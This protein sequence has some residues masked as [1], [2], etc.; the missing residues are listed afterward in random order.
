MRKKW[1]IAIAAILVV[2]ICHAAKNRPVKEKP[3]VAITDAMREDW[4]DSLKV[5]AA[6]AAADL[7]KGDSASA[8]YHYEKVYSL[9]VKA[10]NKTEL[11]P[12][13]IYIGKEYI[14][15][16]KN[17]AAEIVLEQVFNAADQNAR[18]DIKLEASDLLAQLFSARAF[19][20]RANFYL[21]E[22]YALRDK[23]DAL[24][25]QQQKAKLQAEF[26]AMVKAKEKEN[27]REE[28]FSHMQQF[29]V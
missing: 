5:V 6:L 17:K 20:I 29:N 23:A 18:W 22:S 4:N 9:A 1:N 27:N 26:D 15:N 25:K 11:I 24:V 14:R 16:G 12:S 7:Q 13:G 8:M 10:E 28:E 3:Q 19:Y 21:K 2:T